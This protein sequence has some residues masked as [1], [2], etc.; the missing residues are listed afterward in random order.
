VIAGLMLSDSNRPLS[1]DLV[2]SYVAIT[3]LRY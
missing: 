3:D 2:R 1:S